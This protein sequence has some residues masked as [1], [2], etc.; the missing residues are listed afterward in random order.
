MR[1]RNAVSRRRAASES[2]GSLVP[3]LAGCCEWVGSGMLSPPLLRLLPLPV[4]LV[5][6]ITAVPT[7]FSDPN[8]QSRVRT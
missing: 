3:P 2:T 6:L 1:D 7:P 5:V 4:A 8:S